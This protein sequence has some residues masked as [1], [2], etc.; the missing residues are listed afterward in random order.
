MDSLNTQPSS[1]EGIPASA[2][3]SDFAPAPSSPEEVPGIQEERNELN[4]TQEEMRNNMTEMMNLIKIKYEDK[5][6]PNP[7]EAEMIQDQKDLMLRE[8]F[9]MFRKLGV[10]PENTEEVRAYLNEMKESNP[11]LYQQVEKALQTLVSEEEVEGN[12]EPP[13]EEGVNN[14]PSYVEG[15]TG[16]S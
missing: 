15:N 8:V 5:M 3:R 10:D 6:S 1:P 12:Q 16:I 13:I 2:Q 7:N 9:D 4:L 11:E 14:Q